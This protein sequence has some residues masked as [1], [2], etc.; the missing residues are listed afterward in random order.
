MLNI[1]KYPVGNEVDLEKFE[2]G[3][4]ALHKRHYKYF[5]RFLL[6]AFIALLIILFLPWTQNVSGKGYVTTLMPEHRPQTI[7]SPIPGKIEKWYVQ[8]GEFVQKGD[9]ILHISE[10]KGEYFDP[11]LVERTAE[12]LSAKSGSVESYAEKIKALSSQI[13]ALGNERELKRQQ[14]LNKLRQARLKLE[15]D[16]I[17]LEAVKAN[18]DIAQAQ[19][20]RTQQLQQEG[21]KALPDVEEKRQ[22]LQDSR[23]KLISQENKLLASR[24]EV[25]NAQL[26]I[27][28]IAAEYS[29]K[30]SKA[31]SDLHTARSSQY[32][33]AAQVSKLQ[34][35]YSNYAIR[36]QMYYVLAPQK[37]Y[38]NKVLKAGLGETF[39]E[40]ER[41]VE[42]MPADFDLAVET[43]VRPLDVPLMHEGEKVRVQFEGW[44]S[45]V[46]SGWENLSYGTY[47]AKIV[48]VDNF[49]SQ[50]GKYRVLLAP[51]PEDE[52][53]PRG[54]RIGSGATTLALLDEVPIWYEI[55]RNLNGFP[56]DYYQPEVVVE[57]QK[58]QK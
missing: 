9:T 23:A 32:D 14:A 57:N 22:K 47:G 8:E 30:V 11:L 17:D 53:W 19:F 1:S 38:I 42:I 40:G 21:L 2:A 48:A 46:F 29:D 16:S 44:P 3:K 13:N 36:N 10:V 56:P 54:L 26:E 51:D 6:A 33:A 7:Q 24:N 39:K 31:Q 50:N 45:I 37:G 43:Y 15:S 58:K 35:D 25:I 55:W 5:N 4:R 27:N 41:L 34:N 49:I 12:Q 52:P 18:L 20:E 28:R